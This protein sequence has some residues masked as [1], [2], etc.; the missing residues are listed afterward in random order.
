M[1][2]SFTEGIDKISYDLDN[3]DDLK[4][5]LHFEGRLKDTGKAVLPWAAAAALGYGAM[6]YDPGMSDQE[7]FDNASAIFQFT[8]IT[9]QGDPDELAKQ[10]V[11]YALTLPYKDRKRLKNHL[12]DFETNIPKNRRARMEEFQQNINYWV[13][14]FNV[15]RWSS[16]DD[17]SK[18]TVTESAGDAGRYASG[19]LH[20]HA[21]EL[22]SADEGIGVEDIVD[23]IADD[24]A[25]VA[26]GEVSNEQAQE[27][28]DVAVPI[29]TD[30]YGWVLPYGSDI[31]SRYSLP[32]IEEDVPRPT[33]VPGSPF[34]DTVQLPARVQGQPWVHSDDEFVFFLEWLLKKEW[35]ARQIVDI[36]AKPHHYI[37]EYK[38]Y[39][40]QRERQ[41][42]DP[43]L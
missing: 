33:G 19:W 12:K 21:A 29:L 10:F 18:P 7:K 5:K 38:E 16:K 23:R 31:Y 35:T 3:I 41:E 32:E 36:V 20:D 40:D 37:K 9:D 26:G 39:L 8:V 14:K 30:D 25:A 4:D 34:D 15:D 1:M 27:I 22:E 28:V 6:Q 13:N 42:L 11:N 43:L 24:Y 17:S 2:E